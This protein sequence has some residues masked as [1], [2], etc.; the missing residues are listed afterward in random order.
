MSLSAYSLVSLEEI[1]EALSVSGAS[2]DGALE[3]I[4]NGVTDEI[5]DYVGRQIVS[6]GSLTEY[7]TMAAA[8]VAIDTSELLTLEYPILT[9]TTIHED[10]ATPRAYGAAA[11]LTLGTAYE[12]VKGAKPRSLIRRLNGGAGLPWS[13]YVGHRAIKVVYTAGYTLA[14]V[15]DRIRRVALEYASVLWDQHKRGQYG[16]SGQSDGLG[17]YTR[18]ASPQ[19]TDA[20]KAT[21]YGERRHSFYETGERDT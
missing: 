10:V 9:V 2:K 14:T 12:I 17:N 18:F 13:W 19:L 8:G 20:M 11:L 5:E 1:K 15:P 21:L 7:H 16:V 6:R 3:S 4:L